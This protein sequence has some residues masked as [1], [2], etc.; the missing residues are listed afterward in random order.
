ML[1]GP[2][3]VVLDIAVGAGANAILIL[4]GGHDKLEV[5]NLSK[6]RS[7]RAGILRRCLQDRVCRRVCDPQM[8]P[9][10]HQV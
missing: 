3:S 10:N 4:D 8:C 2:V 1:V 9:L 7:R 5:V 6:S